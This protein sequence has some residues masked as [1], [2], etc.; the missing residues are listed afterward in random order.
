M[1]RDADDDAV[2]ETALVGQADALVTR[3]DDLKSPELTIALEAHSLAV[4]TVRHLLVR[5]G[6]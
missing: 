2:I 3:D 6:I 5:L 4:L 1:C